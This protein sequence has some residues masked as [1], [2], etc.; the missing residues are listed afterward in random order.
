M[1]DGSSVYVY[2]YDLRLVCSPKHANL[3]TDQLYSDSLTISNDAIAI[4]DK[5]D[6]KGKS[7][8]DLFFSNLY[9][10]RLVL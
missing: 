9:F 2:N 5:L 6:E 3:H 10:R 7:L 1:A 8:R 4:K